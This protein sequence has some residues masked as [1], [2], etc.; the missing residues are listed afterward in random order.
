MESIRGPF[1]TGWRLTIGEVNEER[2]NLCIETRRGSELRC[3]V[4]LEAVKHTDTAI[5]CNVVND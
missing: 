5:G 3:V 2:V 1:Y 4:S